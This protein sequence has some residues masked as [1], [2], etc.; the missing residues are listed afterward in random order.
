M[1]ENMDKNKTVKI[2]GINFINGEYEDAIYRLN[3]GALMVVPAAPALALIN[4]DAKYYQALHKS[5]FAIPDS[6]FM[7]LVLRLF[8]GIKLKKLS[9][10]EFLKKFLNEEKLKQS[11]S[12]FLIDPTLE[13]SLINN[14]FLR[15][16]GFII[17]KS[18][19]YIAP[20]YNSDNIIDTR[21]LDIIEKKNPKYI[22]INLGGGVQER[23]G[24][25]L[26]N[27]LSYYPG[28]IC[29]GAAIAFLTGRQANIPNFAERVNLGWLYRCINNPKKF[30]PRYLK[31]FLLL[32][33]LIKESI[34]K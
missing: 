25:Y 19:H 9:G 11:N 2:F 22:I 29:T 26:K 20:I 1:R 34:N 21:L 18:N 23:L 6:S 31:G 10:L 27:H 17:R 33:L 14:K 15:K 30:I 4:S 16:N 12:I 8:K 5:D 13:D 3:K 24:L 7:I 32:P 28:I